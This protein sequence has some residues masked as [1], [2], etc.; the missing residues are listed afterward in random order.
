MSWIWKKSPR[1]LM[2]QVSSYSIKAQSL[3]YQLIQS[4]SS[5]EKKVLQGQTMQWFYAEP[6]GKAADGFMES[7]FYFKLQFIEGQDR[8]GSRSEIQCVIPCCALKGGELPP[9]IWKKNLW[10]N[11]SPSILVLNS[12]HYTRQRKGFRVFSLSAWSSWKVI[13]ARTNLSHSS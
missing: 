1:R 5:A 10:Q 6:Q 2:V 8:K 11:S 13:P 9:L 3:S 4:W 7:I 12:I